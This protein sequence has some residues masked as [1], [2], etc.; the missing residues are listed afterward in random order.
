MPDEW[1]RKHEFDPNDGS[2]GSKDN[3]GDGYTNLEE[4]LN[5]ILSSG[6]Q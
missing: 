1:E 3:D 6:S 2:D 5:E 4:Y